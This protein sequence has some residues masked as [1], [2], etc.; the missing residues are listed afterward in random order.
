MSCHCPKCRSVRTKS[1]LRQGTRSSNVSLTS[2]VLVSSM[3]PQFSFSDL[4]EDS[5]P[6]SLKPFDNTFILILVIYES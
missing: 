2:D 1:D 3:G 4:S 5:L 6:A